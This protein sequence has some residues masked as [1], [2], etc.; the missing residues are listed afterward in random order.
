M[1]AAKDLL[2]CHKLRNGQGGKHSSR[3][4]KSQ[5]LI[6]WVKEKRNFEEKLGTHEIL[7]IIIRRRQSEH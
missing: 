2:G 3:S 6:F 7:N 5:A 4:G 1:F